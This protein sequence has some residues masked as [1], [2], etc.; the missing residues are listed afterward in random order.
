MIKNRTI[1]ACKDTQ[2]WY[3]QNDTLLLPDRHRFYHEIRPFYGISC[4]EKRCTFVC[5]FGFKK[6]K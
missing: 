2:V 5:K 6:E 3:E 4:N 1:E